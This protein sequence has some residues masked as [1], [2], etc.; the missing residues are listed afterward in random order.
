M[1]ENKGTLTMKNFV[2][3]YDEERLK[4]LLYVKEAYNEGKLSLEEGQTFIRKELGQISPLEIALAEQELRSFEE[5]QCQKE[6]I[7][8]MLTLF[9]G[10]MDRE[11]PTLPEGHPIRQYYRE[12]AH[13]KDLL[14]RCEELQ[15]KNFIKNQWLELYEEMNTYRIHLQRK[16]NQL[17]PVLEQKGFDRPTT[18]MWTLDDFIRDEM[19]Q[20]LKLLQEDQDEVFLAQQE[21]VIADVLDLMTK[22]ETILYPVSLSMLSLDEYAYM[23]LG[24]KEI[25]YFSLE[26]EDETAF[27]QRVEEVYG[28]SFESVVS[29][30]EAKQ[31]QE[32]KPVSSYSHTRVAEEEESKKGE[33]FEADLLALLEKHGYGKKRRDQDEVFEVATGKLTLEQINLLCKHMPVDLSYVDENNKVAFYSDT[34][35]RVFPRSRN[36]IGRDVYNCHPRKSVHIVEEIIE[37][38]KKGEQSF[39]E[40]WINK[41]DLFIYI[42]YTAVRDEQGRFRGVLEM[43]QDC[44]RIRQL[45]G[46]RTLL[47]WESE[48]QEKASSEQEA[49]SCEVQTCSCKTEASREEKVEACSCEVSSSCEEKGGD[50]SSLQAGQV[51]L[52]LHLETRVKDLLESYPF[53]KKELATLHPAFKALQTPLA[54]IMLPKATLAMMCERS[55]L[56]FEALTQGIRSLIAKYEK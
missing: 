32:E 13:M 49:C 2:E 5:G 3:H 8:A 9:D 26:G 46:S 37:K 15:K 51:E 54:R 43:M 38:F 23:T 19:S 31:N 12:N 4:K 44:T 14:K 22:E 1:Q 42:T 33:A 56:D 24:D 6:D 40:F 34:E 47:A 27:R 18:T 41:P 17:Y 39:A 48:Q 25:G 52:P 28:Q 50:E 35:H 45:E 10:L 29:G 11:M 7:Q 16:Q 53:L 55:G 30:V 20:T 36:V 21:T